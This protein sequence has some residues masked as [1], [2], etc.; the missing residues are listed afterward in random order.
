MVEGVI[1]G[2][3]SIFKGIPFA[4]PPIGDYRWKPPQPVKPWAGTLKADKFGPQCPQINL[5]M[6]D[7]TRIESS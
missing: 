4:V 3:I 7:T 1:N 2:E 6:K 5:D